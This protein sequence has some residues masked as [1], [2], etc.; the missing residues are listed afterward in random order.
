MPLLTLH[1]FT[2]GLLPTNLPTYQPTNQLTSQTRIHNGK[3][4]AIQ[5]INTFPNLYGI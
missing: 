4:T 3:L 1:N 5:L 2:Y